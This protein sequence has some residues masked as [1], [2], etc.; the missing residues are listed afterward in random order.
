M[1]PLKLRK[2][3]ITRANNDN[4]AIRTPQLAEDSMV[5]GCPEVFEA[6]AECSILF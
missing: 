3:T 1:P 6:R 2:N 5:F 4:N